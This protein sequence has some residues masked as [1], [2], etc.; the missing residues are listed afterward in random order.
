MSARGFLR[1]SS[2]EL[3]AA[4]KAVPDEMEDGTQTFPDPTAR[5]DA[6]ALP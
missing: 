4:L 5:R 6:L 1:R 3:P 2:E